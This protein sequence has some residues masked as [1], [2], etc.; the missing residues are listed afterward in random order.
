MSYQ[1]VGFDDEAL[2]ILR[3][4]AAQLKRI[5]DQVEANRPKEWTWES[6]PR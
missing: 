2:S 3:A 1:R 5:A 4:I 6:G